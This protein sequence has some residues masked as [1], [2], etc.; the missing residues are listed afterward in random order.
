MMSALTDSEHEPNINILD[1]E[2]SS[3]LK[4][5]L[6]KHKIKYQLVPTYLDICNAALHAIHTFKLH[7]IPCLCA[8]NPKYPAKECYCFLPQATLTL[9][10]LQNCRFNKNLSLYAAIHGI[11]NYNKTPLETLGTRSLVHKNTANCCT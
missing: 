2:V 5:D 7:F 3:I 4:Q 8:Y 6:L 11:F 9:K 10:L 1:N